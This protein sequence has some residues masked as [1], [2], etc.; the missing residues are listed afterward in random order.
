MGMS[1]A[2]GVHMHHLR[3]I[4]KPQPWFGNTAHSHYA[5]FTIV[6]PVATSLIAYGRW[7]SSD[8][9]LVQQLPDL[10][11]WF[12]I[13]HL[14][15]PIL[16]HMYVWTTWSQAFSCMLHFWL[17][18]HPWSTHPAHLALTSVS[19]LCSGMKKWTFLHLWTLE[20]CTVCAESIAVKL[21]CTR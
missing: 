17:F 8:K 11:D 15:P 18:F 7:C 16:V 14:H 13:M 6:P 20:M 1:P 3:K 2:D 12:Y 10:L 9:R 4:L 21:T 19:S 5:Q